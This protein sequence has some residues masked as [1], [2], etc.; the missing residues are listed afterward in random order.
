M[1][2]ERGVIRVGLNRGAVILFAAPDV[3]VYRGARQVVELIVTFARMPGRAGELRTQ[4]DSHGGIGH[5]STSLVQH[6]KG[7]I[8]AT[9]EHQLEARRPCRRWVIC[10][11]DSA[12]ERGDEPALDDLDVDVC[13]RRAEAREHGATVEPRAPEDAALATR[14]ELHDRS[15]EQATRLV[16]HVH[17]ERPERVGD[18][19]VDCGDLAGRRAGQVAP[20]E[21]SA[22]RVGT[23]RPRPSAP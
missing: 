13:R 2:A 8:D 7:P 9:F 15:H 11:N 17:G 12:T 6:D 14:A 19:Q 16:A 3:Q 21:D 4:S 5:R 22:R 10:E 20:F 18:A 23:R 1:H